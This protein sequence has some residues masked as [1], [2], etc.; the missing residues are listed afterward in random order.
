VTTS[1]EGAS[2][3]RF[4]LRTLGTLR[5]VGSSGA[6]VLGDHGNQ[7]RRL[8]LLAVL[9]A[10]GESGRSRDQ[11]LGLFWPEVDQ[12]RARHSLEQLLYSLRNTFDSDVFSGTSPLRLNPDVIRSDLAA[13]FEAI[14]RGDFAAAVGEYHGRFLD[15]FY[16]GGAAEF[17][18]WVDTE[19]NR[20][21]S[22]YTDALEKL[23]ASAE[24]AGDLPLA[25]RWRQQL[26][27]SD[28]LSSKHATSLIR[29]LMNAGD[30]SSALQHAERYETLASRELGTGVGPAML[31]LVAE[32]RERARTESVVVRGNSPPPPRRDVTS[33]ALN[34]DV[35][36]VITEPPVMNK[37]HRRRSRIPFIAAA[38]VVVA[39]LAA[40]A[41]SR[42]SDA[43]SPVTP[44]VGKSSIAVLPL[45]NV[46]GDI[47]DAS[48]ADGISEEL[49]G[50]LSRI[51][52]LKVIARTSA[53]AFKGSPLDVRQIAES[54][55]VSYVLE[56][57]VQ[58]SGGR[59]RVQ[60]RLIDARDGSTRWSNVY[61]RDISDIFVL[62]SEIAT[63]VARELDLRLGASATTAIRRSPT[64]NLAA[65]ELYLR[66]SDP[67]LLRS[68]S[69]A[70][71]G[72]EYFK[73]AVELDPT[74]AAAHAG[75]ARMRMRLRASRFA[76]VPSREAY[77]LAKQSALTAIAADD[78]SAEAHATAGLIKMVGY[79]FGGADI[80]MKRAISLD[81][82]SSRIREWLV[83]LHVWHGR[84]REAVEEA[85]RALELDPLA[86]SAHAMLGLAL[87]LN[88]DVDAGL[89]VLDGLADLRPPLQR[90]RTF[91]ALCLGK[92]GKW[93]AGIEVLDENRGA[94]DR[95][96]IG[97]YLGRLG[98]RQRA[99]EI[100]EGLIANQ[101]EATSP[102]FI[103]V[104]YAGLGD[105]D[106]FFKW[107]DRSIASA[108]LFHGLNEPLF[109]RVAADPRYAQFRQRTGLQNR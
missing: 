31:A 23:A 25:A 76:D 49:I 61:D 89:R 71:I 64:R 12:A 26:A 97:N 41:G 48:I 33:S 36:P 54:L 95:A 69:T 66:G 46:S 57:G 79:D 32:V 3:P 88:G 82:T 87:C 50:A 106:Q 1:G 6:P 15:G 29:S 24:H 73:Q 100:V 90:T 103:A 8:A 43:E 91:Q 22:V 37:V 55:G 58:R 5:V 62:Q 99:L 81:P 7:R 102:Y 45:A 14:D 44:P 109:D 94:P 18:Q 28:P 34:G 92:A 74:Y 60:V 47:R 75:I 108:S 4:S 70:A 104:V 11:L 96:I 9:A 67:V 38:L 93:R 39:A 101:E 84:R 72:L 27:S 78:S 40:Y 65:Y 107:L 30:F 85:R 19:R 98:E 53:F 63:S 16:L 13:F 2:G 105:N 56:G 59:V 20:I 35:V 68:D 77:A 10:A 17:E 80:A 21:D 52:E 86:P 83:N 42:R 51:S